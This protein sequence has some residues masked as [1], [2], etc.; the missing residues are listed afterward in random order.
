MFVP[1]F[2]I[3]TFGTGTLILLLTSYF[4]LLTS[5][6]ALLYKALQRHAYFIIHAE[7]IL[8]N[9]GAVVTEMEISRILQEKG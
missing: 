2:L 4:L 8:L 1:Q 3:G 6:I 9:L 7:G 5:Y